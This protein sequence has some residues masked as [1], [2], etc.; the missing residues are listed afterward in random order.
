MLA[1]ADLHKAYGATRAELVHR[2]SALHSGIRVPLGLAWR[3]E[4]V[5]HIS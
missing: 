5:A 3:G 4:A 1:I 2:S